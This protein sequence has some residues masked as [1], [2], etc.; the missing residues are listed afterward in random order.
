M[1]DKKVFYDFQEKP[2]GWRDRQ[3]ENW[4]IPTFC[5]NDPTSCN[6]CHSMPIDA[7]E[8]KTY[9]QTKNFHHFPTTDKK[10][11]PTW[12]LFVVITP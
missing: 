8:K 5:L 6:W 2:I 11:T 4:K 10:K 3:K 7:N 1:R 12:Q 9:R